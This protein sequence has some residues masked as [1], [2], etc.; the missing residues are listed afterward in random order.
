MLRRS[1]LCHLRK[2]RQGFFKPKQPVKDSHIPQ[3]HSLP[4]YHY[5]TQSWAMSSPR[6]VEPWRQHGDGF[7]LINKV[8]WVP[9]LFSLF[10]FYLDA[11]SSIFTSR[12]EAILKRLPGAPQTNAYLNF[13]PMLL[14]D[15]LEHPQPRPYV[16]GS[17]C[18]T[19][20]PPV[21]YHHTLWTP[22]STHETELPLYTCIW[23]CS[24]RDHLHSRRWF[25]L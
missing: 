25:S 14:L 9:L 2:V 10:E 15:L 11:I 23:V 6:E 16:F 8:N 5:Y 22:C 12:T 17:D 3:G 21:K 20:P 13:L 4:W 18:W 24:F 7:N 19:V 1:L